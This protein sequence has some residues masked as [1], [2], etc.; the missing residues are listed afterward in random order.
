MREGDLFYL[1]VYNDTLAYEVDQ[2]LKVE[3]Q[4]TSS[5]AIEEGEDYVTL[6]TCTPY[7]VN[8]HRLLVRGHRVLYEENVY[9]E[10]VEHTMPR[11]S[12]SWGMHFLCALAGVILA[13]FLCWILPGKIKRRR[14]RDNGK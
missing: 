11:V 8:T 9:K 1:K 12:S 3:P 5:L 2:I 4:E 10:A 7:A 14:G 13:V 6:V